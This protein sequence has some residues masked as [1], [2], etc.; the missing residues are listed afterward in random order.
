MRTSH[1]K[2]AEI[3][4]ALHLLQTEGQEVAKESVEESSLWVHVSSQN[5]ISL[6]RAVNCAPEKSQQGQARW[7]M[8]VSFLNVSKF[9]FVTAVS[10]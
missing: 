3:P 6:L 7:E 8:N 9:C 10:P 4:Q 5:S 2:Y 1:S